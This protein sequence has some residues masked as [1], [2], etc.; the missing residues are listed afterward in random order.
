M[1]YRRYLLTEIMVLFLI[2][3]LNLACKSETKSPSPYPTVIS[4]K[5]TPENPR[6][7]HDLSITMEGLE[8]RDLTFKYLWK[9]TGEEIFGETFK[10]LDSLNFSKHD[11]ISVVVTPVQGEIMGKPVESDPVVIMNTAPVISL[12]IIQPQ[13]AYISSQLEVMV[14]AS[15]EDDDYIVYSYRWIKNDQDIANET[16]N[17]LSSL[18]FERGDSIGCEVTPSDREVEGKPFTTE[19][20]VIANSPPSITSQPPSDV[21][22]KDFFTY[23]VVADDLDQDNLVFSLASSAPEGMTI[24]PTTGIIKWKIPKDLTG[25]Y[26]IEIIVSDGYG[27]RCSQRFNLSIGEDTG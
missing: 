26:P 24:D 21:V 16:A 3:G 17:V 15:D 4:V 25:V 9:R 18:N 19:P 6:T 8:G 1:I 13:P 22:L 14:D 5:I 7:T 10:T 12:A 27:G 11:T 2:T 23:R 20:I